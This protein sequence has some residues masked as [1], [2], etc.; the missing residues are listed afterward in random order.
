MKSFK[1]GKNL[2]I[3]LICMFI[4]LLTSFSVVFPVLKNIAKNDK[5][6]AQAAVEM[7]PLYGRYKTA[8]TYGDHDQNMENGVDD[9]VNNYNNKLYY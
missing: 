4:M 5:E 9:V 2:I 6:D 7:D 8:P 3:V 1:R